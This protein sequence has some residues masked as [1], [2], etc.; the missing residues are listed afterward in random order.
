[1]SLRTRIILRL[2]L[3]AIF[4]FVFQIVIFAQDINPGSSIFVYKSSRATSGMMQTNS[5]G[6]NVATTSAKP[7]PKVKKITATGKKAQGQNTIEEDAPIPAE[8]WINENA[9]YAIEERK[10]S[11]SEPFLSLTKGYLNSNYQFCESPQFP[12]AARR[13]KQKLVESK[14]LVTVAK[15][16]G[17]LNA[18]IIEDDETFRAAVYKTLGSMRFRESYFMGQ[19]IRVEGILDFTQ[20]PAN[21]IVCNVASQDLVIPPA[22]EG[23]DLTGM[24]KTCEPPEF[25]ASA[26]SAGLKTVDAKVQ[27]IVGEDGKVTLAKLIEGNPAFGEAAVKAAQKMTFPRSMIMEKYVMVRGTVTF[28]QTPDNSVSCS[29]MKG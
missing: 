2:S 15:Y 19:K 6:K 5:G 11:D 29:Q 14:V 21:S 10:V 22:I 16:G 20:N 23:G 28:K 27:I 8:D 3:T 12:N 18:H 7:K 9:D 17:V 25:P 13:A 1:M 24:A 4:S 26:K